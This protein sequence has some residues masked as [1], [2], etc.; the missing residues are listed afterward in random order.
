MGSARFLRG[1]RLVVAGV[2][3]LC[4]ALVTCQFVADAPDASAATAPPPTRVS[5]SSSGGNTN[6]ASSSPAISSHGRYVAFASSVTNLVNGDTNHASDVFV[7]DLVAHTTTLVSVSTGGVIGNGPSDEP[8]ISADGQHVAFESSATNLTHGDTNG[9]SDIF[10]RDL[11]AKT[12]KRMSVAPGGIQ[13]NA[14]SHGPIISGNGSLIAFTSSATN[15]APTAGNATEAFTHNLRNGSTLL[16]SRGV[17]ARNC[18]GELLYRSA[19]S[20]SSDGKHIAISA[21]CPGY[22]YLYDRVR[23]TGATLLVAQ[24]YTGSG[25]GGNIW[26][27]RYTAT[28]SI[29]AYVFTARGEAN[30]GFYNTA[31][32][33]GDSFSADP[34]TGVYGGDFGLSA[35]GQRIVYVG[36]T[37]IDG[38]HIFPGT[39]GQPAIYSYDR[40]G[41]T[42][43]YVSVPL[44]GAS[45]EANDS[46][47]SPALSADG[48]RAA[49]VCTASD[50]V[51]GD[52]NG[53]DDIFARPVTSAPIPDLQAKASIADTAVTEPFTGSTNA[54]LTISLDRPIG[55]HAEIDVTFDDITAT[56]GVD[57][58]ATP[59]YIDLNAGDTAATIQVPIYADPNVDGDETFAAH[60]TVYEGDATLGSHPNA[61]VTI[62]D[63]AG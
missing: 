10:M 4:S 58:D 51:T 53:A 12:T 39:I 26:S 33:T 44:G 36:G 32:G 62:H 23:K 2:V 3:C 63:P 54:A 24:T 48:S 38:K 29:L 28:G 6:G 55:L 11:V 21:D 14:E 27:V 56:A 1:N 42:I 59:Q 60:L 20:L 15:L 57:Y 9:V 5:V 17:K 52:F 61:I 35:D 16:A 46:C 25:G 30:V 40:T 31:D 41:G 49:F 43:R 8:A 34:Q 50:I 22:E 18:R 47:S 19:A 7:R 37:G 45:A 13:A